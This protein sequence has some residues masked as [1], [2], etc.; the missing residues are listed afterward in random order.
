M[1]KKQNP[2]AIWREFE[3]KTADWSAWLVLRNGDVVA[4]IVTHYGGRRSPNGL[5]VRAFVHV[6][7]LPMV[8]GIARG[9]GYDMR[10]AAI[11]SACQ[12]IQDA[13]LKHLPTTQGEDMYKLALNEQAAKFRALVDQGHDIPHQL[14]AMGYQVEQVM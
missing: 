10:T 12:H 1:S 2:A 3:T 13:K 14:R 9:G 11:A 5:T 6:L 4:K 7:G 8:R